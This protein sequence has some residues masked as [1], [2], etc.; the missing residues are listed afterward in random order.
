VSSHLPDGIGNPFA[1]MAVDA[2]DPDT[3]YLGGL[4]SFHVSHDGGA[5]FTPVDA[6]YEAEK[7]GARKLWTDRYR[8]GRVYATPD[9]GG[10]FEGHFE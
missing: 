5:T 8:P 2:A 6:P 1:P 10:L 3:V 4:S 7:R 9:N